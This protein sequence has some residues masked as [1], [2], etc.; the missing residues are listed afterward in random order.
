MRI[1][2]YA[3]LLPLFTLAFNKPCAVARATST[4]HGTKAVRTRCS[5]AQ[6]PPNLETGRLSEGTWREPASREVFF[7]FGVNK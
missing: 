2:V 1:I 4:A 5:L 6:T 7:G 3:C